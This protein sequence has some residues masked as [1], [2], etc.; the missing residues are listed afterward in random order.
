MHPKLTSDFRRYTLITLGGL[1][2][3]FTFIRIFVFKL[4]ETPRYLLSQGRDQDAVDAVNHVARQ[5]GKPEPL[6]IGMLREIDARLGNSTNEEGETTRMS[7]KEIVKENMQAFRGEHYRALFATRKLARQT[8]IIWLIW[9]TVGKLRLNST[10][11]ISTDTLSRNRVPFV[12]CILAFL[13]GN[14]VYRNHLVVPDISELLHH[15]SCR[16]RWSLVCRSR[17]QHSTRATLDDGRFSSCH[18]GLSV[19]I[20]Q[21]HQPVRRPRLFLHY[22]FTG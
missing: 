11:R 19:C 9:L 2:L 10:L 21:R 16:H 5:N 22:Q 12:L 20:C 14:Q 18:C 15:V 7:T 8:L 3:A 4:P 6:T 17:R 13:F 1:A